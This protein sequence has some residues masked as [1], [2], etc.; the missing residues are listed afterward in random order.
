MSRSSSPGPRTE[1]DKACVRASVWPGYAAALVIAATAYL[2]HYLPFAP[3]RVAG[4]FGVRR[5]VS[6]AIIAI[7][8][9]ALARNGFRLPAFILEGCKGIVQKGHPRDHRPYGLQPESHQH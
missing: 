1:K 5:P 4:E 2:I 6:P 9:G 7:L 3:F 8:L